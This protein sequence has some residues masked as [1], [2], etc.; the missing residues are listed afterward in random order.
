MFNT[1]S[2]TPIYFFFSPFSLEFF[3]FQNYTYSAFPDYYNFFSSFSINFHS[4]VYI[5]KCS[6]ILYSLKYI[7]HQ[8]PLSQY[9][10]RFN[11]SYPFLNSFIPH[12]CFLLHKLSFILY[13]AISFLGTSLFWYIKEYLCSLLTKVS[14][15]AR[16]NDFFPLIC[17]LFSSITLDTLEE[18]YSQSFSAFPFNS[19]YFFA[20][21]FF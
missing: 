10:I 11:N 15:K 2:F 8:P 5:A 7:F 17:F 18:Y 19:K 13:I 1:L 3:T 14:P 16:F 12:T 4:S 6:I 21:F 20:F 9:L